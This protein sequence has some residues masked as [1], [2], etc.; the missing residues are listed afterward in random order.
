MWAVLA[1]CGCP[2]DFVT[3]IRALHDGMLGRVCHQNAL[4]DP[5]PIIGGLKQGYVLALTYF[6]LDTAVM[7]NEIPPETPS[8]EVK[9]YMYGGV[10]NLARPCARTKTSI[11]SIRELQYAD[12]NP[13]SC[14]IVEDLQRT[15]IAYNTAYECFG[16]QVNTDKT[17]ALIQH[18]PGQILPNANTTI[19]NQ[20]LEEVDQL[21]YLGSMLTSNPTC[22]KDVESRIR[23]AHSAYGCLNDRVLNNH[24]LT[25]N[26]KIMVFRAVVLSTLLYACE[27]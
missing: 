6:S 11:I 8:I 3:L 18:P 1:R 17:K 16:M 12:D 23:A 2:P 5:F 15:A 9:Y 4:S 25:I 24:A 27:T 21:S 10:F 7:M 20:P 13:T 14:Q 19:N 26:T 22:K